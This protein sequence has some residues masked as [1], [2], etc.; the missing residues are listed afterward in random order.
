M[1]RGFAGWIGV[2]LV[3]LVGIVGLGVATTP[4]AWEPPALR[5]HVPP[6]AEVDVAALTQALSD[7]LRVD[8]T[9]PPG[10]DSFAMAAQV[11]ADGGVTG[12]PAWV[13][14][15]VVRW[16][17]PLGL[18]WEMVEG[19]LAIFVPS[20]DPRPPV[21]WLSHADVVPVA[22]DELD[23]WTHPPGQ[24]VVADGFVWGRGALDNKSSTIAQL[25]ALSM[26]RA[27]GRQASRRVVLVIT[28][29]EETGGE[30]AAAVAARGLERLGHP[31]TVLD[32]GSYIL[33]DLLPGALVGGVAVSEKTYASFDL[34][35]QAQG[36]HSSMPSGQSAIDILAAAVGRI[37]A[38]QTPDQVTPAMQEGFGRLAGHRAFPES[39]VLGHAGLLEP[40]MLPVL[41][42][43]AAGNA[44]S[45]DTIVVT[46]IHAGVK[47]N[48]IPSEATATANARLL[49]STDPEAFLARLVEVVDDPRVVIT[50]HTWNARAGEG[51]WNTDAFRALE[52]VIPAVEPGTVV[53][54]SLTP[55]TMDARHFGAAGLHTYRFH[56]YVLDKA[57]RARLHG[58]DERVSVDNLVRGVRFYAGLLSEL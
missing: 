11:D 2:G 44:I 21:M 32:E 29:D 57:E 16:V 12:R 36:G 51:V 14:H 9:N 39:L 1:W 33:P 46:M 53:I 34:S 35:V 30:V 48:V 26:L 13:D 17:E 38:W 20:E 56:P 25:T 3:G 19:A 50:P 49:P 54:P 31:D 45:R 18:R 55:A 4:P 23:R 40:L 7:Y 24:G 41:Q 47:D 10:P 27:S 28:P 5:G 52:A 58:L 22:D 43:T 6:A 42:R 15:L 8:T 37:G